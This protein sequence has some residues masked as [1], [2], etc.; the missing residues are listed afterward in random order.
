MCNCY[1]KV[2]VNETPMLFSDASARVAPILSETTVACGDRRDLGGAAVKAPQ[3]RWRDLPNKDQ[4]FILALCRLSEPLSNV[5]LLPYIFYLVR[6]VLPPSDDDSPDTAAARISEY[7][8][9]L[10][11]A[12]P[13][14][15]SRI[16]TR[17]VFRIALFLFPVTYMTAPYLSLLAVDH[18]ADARWVFLGFVVCAQIMA[19]T[20]A[21]PSTVILLTE[22][23]PSK[24]VL[25]TV[26]GAANTLASLARAAGPAVGGYVFAVGAKEGV[27][28]LVWWLY[29]VGVAL[30]ALAWSYLMEEE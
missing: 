27:I 24:I 5:C 10:V 28:G 26:H 20:M 16:G 7:S 23:A 6:S 9:L 14:A 25:G 19:R 22:A 11:A 8:G 30:S 21:I 18:D 2:I 4:L 1:K 15:Q 12:F 17:G 29:L 13:L 3:V